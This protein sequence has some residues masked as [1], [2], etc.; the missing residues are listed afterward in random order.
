MKEVVSLQKQAMVAA[1]MERA[2]SHI[3]RQY[4]EDVAAAAAAEAKIRRL[5][6]E[7]K[8]ASLNGPRPSAP[9]PAVSPTSLAS[10]PTASSP[11]SSLTSLASS[12]LEPAVLS[13]PAVAE[14]ENYLAGLGHDEDNEDNNVTAA[15][16][17]VGRSSKR[18]RKAPSKFD[19]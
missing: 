12:P 9:S 2:P 3:R 11:A 19:D 5:E 10:A 18:Q 14:P 15:E 6:I 16:E 4:E 13:M 8:L 7:A 1:S 17:A